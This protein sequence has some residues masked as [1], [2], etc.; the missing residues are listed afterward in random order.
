MLSDL[1]YAFRL[2][3]KHPGQTLLAVLTLSLGIGLTC[4]CFSVTDALVFR[5]LLV[6]EPD[7]LVAVSE[8]TPGGLKTGLSAANFLDLRR[9]SRSFQAFG[10]YGGLAL[11]LTGDGLP[12]RVQGFSVTAGV[13]EALGVNASLGRTLRPEDEQLDRTVVVL[14]HRL[15]RQRF[16]AD[17]AIVGRSVQLNGRAYEVVGVMPPEALFPVTAELWTP[18]VLDATVRTNRDLHSLNA[19]ARLRPG[20]T[21]EQGQAEFATLVQRLGALYP[22]TNAGWGTSVGLLREQ[23]SGDATTQY[24]MLTVGAFAFVL[25]I[26]CVNVANMQLA[27]GPGRV[28]EMAVRVALGS[29]RWRIV[30][31]LLAENIVLALAGILPALLLALWGTDLCRTSMPPEVEQFLPGW[32]RLRVNGSVVM[33][34]VLAALASGLLAGIIPALR[35]SLPAIGPALKEGGRGGASR[36]QHRLRS[37]LVVSE[38]S[39]ALTL[40]VGASLLVTGFLALGR[41]SPQLEPAT[42]LTFRTALPAATYPQPHHL[43]AFYGQMLDKLRAMPGV[44]AALVSHI[45]YGW[46]RAMGV[47]TVEGQPPL[48]PGESRES[49]FLWVSDGYFELL[50]IPIQSGRGFNERDGADAPAV[51]I[52]SRR[53]A[54]TYW[55]GENP[56]GK[57]LKAGGTEAK[58]PWLTVVGVADDVVHNWLDRVP[59]PVFYRPFLQAPVQNMDVLLRT[60]GDPLR[61]VPDV[62]AVIATLDPVLPIYN[63][64]TFA[65]V[66]SDSLVGYAYTAV[67]LA[68]AGGLAA[69]LAAIGV[70]AVMAQAVAE[71]T[72]EI[73]VRM[74][75]GARTAD[76]LAWILRRGLVLGLAGAAIGLTGAYLLARLLGGL[77]MGV[78]PTNP[79]LFSAALALL[80][81]VIAAACYFP[82]RRATRVD[83]MVALRYE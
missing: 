51:A 54:E 59:R 79:V 55:P 39:L 1:R 34:S 10:A 8:V 9:D 18:L 44:H 29:G 63:V 71:R 26:V 53:F 77:L 35:L 38:E 19:V 11:N 25:L 31:Q 57:R 40:L 22:Q 47:F 24:T 80:L 41:W 21:L 13:F 50:H 5:P 32:Q 36:G 6:P 15:W 28:R 75:L 20:V 45:P 7:R 65:K 60:S 83:P 37:L 66:I 27:R 56:L 82:A 61:L 48:R 14:S 23:I 81:A 42:V 4:I 67:M 73:G 12:E 64:K 70:Y 43:T 17:P 74:A 16:A 46:G 3:A 72:H 58:S 62:R 30:R 69:L 52:V 78:D 68:V 76:V 49:Q 2:L 33:F